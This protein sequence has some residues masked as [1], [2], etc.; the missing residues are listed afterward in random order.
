[1]R[2]ILFQLTKFQ[3]SHTPHAIVHKPSLSHRLIF[4]MRLLAAAFT[5]SALTLGLQTSA[6]TINSANTRHSRTPLLAVK[7]EATPCDIPTDIQPT[8]A[9]TAQPNAG[10]I[11]RSAV[12]TDI[13]G[14]FLPLDRPMGQGTSVVIFLRHMG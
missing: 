12:V 5:A 2:H 6:F 10:K 9:L 13:N 14:D 7:A 3:R 1:M 4:T 11:L 8:T